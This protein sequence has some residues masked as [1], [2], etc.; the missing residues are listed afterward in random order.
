[1]QFVDIIVA[2]E[3]CEAWEETECFDEPVVTT[4]EIVRVRGEEEPFVIA[5]MS[6]NDLLRRGKQL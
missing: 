6:M 4:V 3:D 2:D 5:E 1:M